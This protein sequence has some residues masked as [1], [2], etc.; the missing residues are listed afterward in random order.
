[1]NPYVIDRSKLNTYLFL[2]VILIIASFFL[3]YFTAQYQAGNAFSN[4]ES[5]PTVKPEPELQTNMES[6]ISETTLNGQS[7]APAKPTTVTTITKPPAKT[8]SKSAKKTV[9]KPVVQKKPVSQTV[10]SP[11]VKNKP[12]PKTVKPV[13]KDMAA[14]ST[15]GST[16]ANTPVSS[17]ELKYSVQAGLFGNLVNANK[18]LDQLQIAGF[19][20]YMDDHQDADGTIRYNVRF[21][22][23]A[24]RVEAEQRLETYRQGF[25][26]P[27]YVII[28]P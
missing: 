13:I 6:G 2:A 27:A 15:P 4:L 25:S 24:S 3:G 23:F 17:G 22:R 9:K 28:N 21:G 7:V 19:D 1:M 14:V 11:R 12:V 16:L 20:A 10:K 8:Q 26:T 5:E 18:F